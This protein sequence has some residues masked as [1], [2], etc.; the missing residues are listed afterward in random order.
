MVTSITGPEARAE[1]QKDLL[2]YLILVWG[3]LVLDLPISLNLTFAELVDALHKG[4]EKIRCE[5][6]FGKPTVGGFVG[7][8]Y[9]RELFPP[10]KGGGGQA[11]TMQRGPS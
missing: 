5:W 10:G 9:F 2:I 4:L 8:Y 6:E 3:N 7:G 11:E 1:K